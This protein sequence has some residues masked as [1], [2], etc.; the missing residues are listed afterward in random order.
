M[1]S[2]DKPA[3]HVVVLVHG[4]RD[5][6]L[7]QE[8]VRA[9][10]E[11][12][13]LTVEATNYGRMNVVQFL[14][15]I[16]YFRNKAIESLDVQI[17]TIR[18]ENPTARLSVI[19]HSFGTYAIAQLMKKNFDREFYHVIFCGSVVPLSFHF[20][21][22][23][24]RFHGKIWNEV[25]TRDFWPAFAESIGFRYG[26]TGTYGFRKPLVRDQWH[27]G[28]RHNYF[29]SAE[30]CKK[31][32][33]PVL[34]EQPRPRTPEKPENPLRLARLVS[35]L[36]IKYLLTTLLVGLALFY[37]VDSWKP[38]LVAPFKWWQKKEI[39]LAPLSAIPNPATKAP[40]E[41]EALLALLEKEAVTPERVR[42]LSIQLT[43]NLLPI[44]ADQRPVSTRRELNRLTLKTL[45]SINKRN[46]AEVWRDLPIRL[47]LSHADFSGTDLH[48]VKFEETDL[49]E[50]EF[51]NANLINATFSYVDLRQ[52]NFYG[53]EMSG[54]VFRGTDWFNASNVPIASG[55]GPLARTHAWLRCPSDYKRST[56]SFQSYFE[57]R[58][59]AP[60]DKLPSNN[61]A[62]L[63]RHWAVYSH[64]DGLCDIVDN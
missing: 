57:E 14:I 26:A 21:Q 22:I 52:A 38:D 4:I 45:L 5:H 64:Y 40:Q 30:F 23:R 17:R 41:W 7:W 19:A 15:P 18:K 56:K 53:A 59:H 31:F 9:T 27:N 12:A 6:A 62:V 10:L 43:R 24:Q 42:E 36:K 50:A 58:Y 51:G 13:G 34:T 32:W 60:F 8:N 61:M 39:V 33:L 35:F 2:A 47:D 16:S 25:G 63:T 55:T 49:S 46:L 44:N 3:N 28:A 54:V 11:E 48:G 29:L 37:A 20:E 1:N